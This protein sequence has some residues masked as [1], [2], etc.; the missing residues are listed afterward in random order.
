MIQARIERCQGRFQKSLDLL[1]EFETRL[2]PGEYGDRFDLPL[3]KYR[4][5]TMTGRFREAEQILLQA[6]ITAERLNHCE[7][8]AHLLKAW[9]MSTIF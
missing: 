7:T 1:D 2:P 5:L 6:L 9:A 3:E 8:I 4:C